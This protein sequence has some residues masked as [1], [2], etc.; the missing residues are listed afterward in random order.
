MLCLSVE[1]FLAAVISL[2]PLNWT[3]PLLSAPPPRHQ[4]PPYFHP[5]C[6]RSRRSLMFFPCRPIFRSE[7]ARMSG[8]FHTPSRWSASSS[9]WWWRRG[10]NRDPLCTDTLYF[11][12]KWLQSGCLSAF[13]L[14]RC[15]RWAEVLFYVLRALNKV[16][17]L[18]EETNFCCFFHMLGMWLF[19]TVRIRE[20]AGGSEWETLLLW[21]VTWPVL[22]SVSSS[23]QPTITHVISPK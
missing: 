7:R 3:A 6:P 18:G 1:V 17:L 10:R 12:W 2:P 15:F 20:Q 13:I 9:R 4:F 23:P 21:C 8:V 11:S 16:F 19:V 14:P 5:R 22:L